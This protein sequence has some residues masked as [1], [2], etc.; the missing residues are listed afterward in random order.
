MPS[1]GALY[2]ADAGDGTVRVS[3]QQDAGV[4]GQI[5]L[6]DDADNIRMDSVTN[7]LIV[8]YGNGGLTVI[9]VASFQQSSVIATQRTSRRFSTRSWRQ[10]D[11]R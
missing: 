1:I 9:D 6:G 5:D 11:L 8:G 2:V 3:Q 10:S 7:Q 4:T